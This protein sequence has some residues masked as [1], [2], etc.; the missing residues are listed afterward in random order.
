MSHTRVVIPG[1]TRNLLAA[2]LLFAACTKV[3]EEEL[4][5]PVASDVPV[6]FAIGGQPTKGQMPITTLAELATQ[7]FSVSAW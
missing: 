5:L 1:L 2:L 3:P 4:R 7:D 6:S